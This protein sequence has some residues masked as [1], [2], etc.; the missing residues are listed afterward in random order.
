MK[1][2]FFRTVYDVDNNSDF[3]IKIK[4]DLELDNIPFLIDT[5]LQIEKKH[6]LT[7]NK[8]RVH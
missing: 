3:S 5:T 2:V 7:W 4:I 6:R 8:F 1:Y